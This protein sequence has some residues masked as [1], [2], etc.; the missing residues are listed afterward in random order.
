MDRIFPLLFVAVILLGMEKY[1]MNKKSSSVTLT[2]YGEKLKKSLAHLRYSLHKV[3]KLSAE[4]AHMDEETL[5]TWES[6]TSRF[7]RT[8]DIFLTKY[9]RAAVLKDDPGFSGSVRDFADYAE[10]IGLLASADQWMEFR[11]FRNLIVHEYED[12]D[13]QKNLED[14]RRLAPVVLAIEQ[15]LNET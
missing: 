7:S 10:K 5:E 13:L 8:V 12:V 6:F 14:L 4:V 2:L 9:V 15:H 11:G 3:E 1:R